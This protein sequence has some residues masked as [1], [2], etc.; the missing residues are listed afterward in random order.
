MLRGAI[1]RRLKPL[2][3][4]LDLVYYQ[5]ARGPQGHG[6]AHPPAY[7][8]ERYWAGHLDMFDSIEDLPRYA[9]LS[10]YIGSLGGARARILDLGCGYG[11][12][13]ELL[14]D[15]SFAAYV[16]IDISAVA[17]AHARARAAPNMRFEVRNL[18]TW[19]PG[20]C[21][22]I[23]VFNEVLYYLH[24]PVEVMLRH[25]RALTTAG[26]MLVSMFRH[27]NSDIIWREI[28]KRFPP[29]AAVQLRNPR[30]ELT[31]IRVL[32]RARPPAVFS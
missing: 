6:L 12:L 20:E 30:N 9:M 10:A 32:G 21:F 13:A 18:S 31:D 3:H 15:G 17:V 14:G 28:H 11:R 4:T 2:F 22:D 7:W 27:G 26:F 25:E 5:L 19:E 1:F 23:I 24:D 16:G 8:D 29:I